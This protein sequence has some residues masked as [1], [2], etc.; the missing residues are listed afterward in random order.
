[1]P[2][3]ELDIKAET[4]TA[5]GKPFPRDAGPAVPHIPHTYAF[6]TEVASGMIAVKGKKVGLKHVGGQNYQL[7]FE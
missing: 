7:T 2:K 6:V 3:I 5:D 4:I 1:M